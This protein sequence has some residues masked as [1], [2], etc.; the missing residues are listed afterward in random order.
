MWLSFLFIGVLTH[1]TAVSSP[2]YLFVIPAQDKN[3]DQSYPESESGRNAKP[4]SR[5]KEWKRSSNRSATP[6]VDSH[7]NETSTSG[8]QNIKLDHSSHGRKAGQQI[9][10]REKYSN[11]QELQQS[12]NAESRRKS[13]NSKKSV[14]FKSLSSSTKNSLDL[15][16][17][18]AGIDSLSGPGNSKGDDSNLMS[19]ERQKVQTQKSTNKQQSSE[20]PSNRRENRSHYDRSDDHRDARNHRSNRTSGRKDRAKTEDS[21]LYDPYAKPKVVTVIFLFSSVP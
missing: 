20:M 16:E 4:K 9:V 15:S 10:Q 2:R 5:Q 17:L 19:D 1:T 18:E 6:E 7:R 14:S 13:V 21:R 3:R 12:A 8:S 11:Q